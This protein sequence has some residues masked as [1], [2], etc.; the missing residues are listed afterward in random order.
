MKRQP[1]KWEKV[2]TNCVLTKK[3]V[4][5][6]Y[7]RNSYNSMAEKLINQFKKAKNTQPYKDI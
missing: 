1:T 2:F 6:I 7:I 3:L 5:K 4:S